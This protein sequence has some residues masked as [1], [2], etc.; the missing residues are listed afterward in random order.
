MALATLTP[1]NLTGNVGLVLPAAGVTSIAGTTGV[2]F[3][4][5]GQMFLYLTIG[6]ATTTLTMSLGRT[7]EGQAPAPFTQALSTSTN[8]LFGPWSPTDFTATDGSGLT[9]FTMSGALTGSA[10]SLYLLS[11]RQ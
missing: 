11:P 2:Q 1:I 8:Y 10:A 6:S 7:V 3:A 4:N 5:N 9:Y